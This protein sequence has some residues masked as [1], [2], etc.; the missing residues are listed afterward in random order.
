MTD[1]CLIFQSMLGA[2]YA[3]YKYEVGYATQFSLAMVHADDDMA[4]SN[5]RRQIYYHSTSAFEWD[6]WSIFYTQ[7]WFS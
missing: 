6:Y 7:R 2:A 4:Y 1:F 3:T 5:V